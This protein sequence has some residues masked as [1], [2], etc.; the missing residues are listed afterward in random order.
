MRDAYGSMMFCG[1]AIADPMTGLHAALAA[2]G[3]WNEGGGVLLDISMNAVMAHAIAF[4]SFVLE[5]G[6]NAIR[7]RALNWSVITE[8]DKTLYAMRSPV[9]RTHSLGE[10]TTAVFS[11]LAIC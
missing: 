2:W 4:D 5:A 1:D 8:E 6:K 3:K 7:D 10:D 9:G 11:R